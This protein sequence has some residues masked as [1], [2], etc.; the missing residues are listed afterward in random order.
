[1]FYFIESGGRTLH[2][3]GLDGL[4][5]GAQAGGD[6]KGR[7]GSGQRGAMFIFISFIVYG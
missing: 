4:G 6:G 5:N 2:F 1:M 3:L 7:P